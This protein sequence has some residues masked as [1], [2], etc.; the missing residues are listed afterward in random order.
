MLTADRVASTVL[1]RERFRYLPTRTVNV[2]VG[3]GIRSWQ[4]IADA[5]DAE[6]LAVHGLSKRTVA[7][8]RLEQRRQGL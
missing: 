4:Q 6:L 8:I 7:E 2:L 5:T 3:S 1:A